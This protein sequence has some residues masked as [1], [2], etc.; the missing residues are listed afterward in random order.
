MKEKRVVS[1]ESFKKL[2]II[3]YLRKKIFEHKF[4]NHNNVNYFRGVF[5]SFAE[6]LASAPTTKPIGYNN[7]T[8][9]KLYKDRTKQIYS[10]DYPVLFW[11]K[12]YLP[13]IHRVFDFGGHVGI[14]FYAYSKYLDYNFI[15]EWTIC[16]VAAVVEEAK[17]LAKDQSV[18]PDVNFCVKKLSFSNDILDCENYD[19][20]LASGSLQYL[21]WDLDEKLKRLSKPPRFLIINLLPLHEK[22]KTITLQSIG[23]SFCPY[24]VRLE[25]DFIN[26]LQNIGY[27][28]VN[29]WNN[30]EKICNIAFEKERSLKSYKG[31]LFQLKK[32]D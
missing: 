18:D 25:S 1:V 29:K 2:P 19:L 5:K 8:A 17:E 11:M 23:A 9:A 6:A 15:K 24:N 16:D 30:E 27:E 10:T 26:G 28:L 14:H 13:E 7:Q 20:F 21:E 22:Y 12:S 4:S 31:M 3:L 32:V